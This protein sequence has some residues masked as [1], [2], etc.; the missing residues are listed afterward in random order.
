MIEIDRH[1]DLSY[2]IPQW[3]RRP[4]LAMIEIDRHGGLSY[5]IPQW[6]RRLCLANPV[7]RTGK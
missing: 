5:Y 3:A 7:N 1:G 6:A 2:Y 4:C